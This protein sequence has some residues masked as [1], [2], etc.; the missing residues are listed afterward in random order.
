MS[1]NTKSETNN[2]Y[3][4]PAV[5]GLMVLLASGLS[6][7]QVDTS[8]EPETRTSISRHV[9]SGGRDNPEVATESTDD[10]AP[11]VTDGV[12]SKQDTRGGFSKFGSGSGQAESMSYDFWF[13]D[14]DVVLLNDD[15]HDGYF[16]TIDLLFDVDTNFESADIYAVMYLSYEGGPWNEY[17][18]T[19]DFTIF[20]A[21]STDE[22]VLVSDLMS[23][24]PTGSYDL[25]IEVFDA[26]DGT[27]LTSFG[28]EDTSELSYLDLEDYNRDAPPVVI[29]QRTVVNRGGGGAVDGWLI[30]VLLIVLLGS[31]MRRIWR[32]R[33]DSLVRIDTPAPIWR[34]STDRRV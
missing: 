1:S 7:A 34:S 17:A 16:Y 33:N 23:G 13:Y 6:S 10:Y 28:P 12:R 9:V 32:H 11:L 2:R 14:V 31:G 18:A 21:S 30:G 22:Y 3:G 20:G 4:L 24:Y 29:E 19:D 5:A 27:Y 26:Y 25:L 8:T 15:D